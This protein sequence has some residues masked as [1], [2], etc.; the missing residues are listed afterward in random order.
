MTV[1]AATAGGCVDESVV[2]GALSMPVVGKRPPP[3]VAAIREVPESHDHRCLLEHGRCPPG[4]RIARGTTLRAV[5]PYAPYPR[6]MTN[7]L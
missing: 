5:E 2:A 7:S 6:G 3:P 4:S 1:T